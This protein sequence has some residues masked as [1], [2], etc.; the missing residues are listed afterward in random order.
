MRAI[1][2][3]FHVGAF[4]L[5]VTLPA[6][7]GPPYLTDDPEP[8]DLHHYEIYAFGSGTAMRDGMDSEAGID[9]N[10]GGAENLQLTAILPLT[11]E[12]SGKAGLGNI[13]LA[14]KYRFLEQ[15][16]FGFDVAAFPALILPS[17]SMDIGAQ[18]AALFLPLWAQKDF[19]SWSVFGGGGCTLNQSGDDRNFCSMGLAVTKEVVDGWRL[20]IEVFH[21]TADSIDAKASTSLG[22]GLTYDLSETF[23]LLAYGGPGL[24]NAG[25]AGRY[26]WYLS[27]LITF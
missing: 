5:L 6:Y 11:Y 26:N 10:Y 24:Q 19:G 4:L 8:T 27:T 1:P 20:G 23:H 22:M 21:Q 16:D 17:A 25:D 9:F 13:E 2:Q 3:P 12:P 18:H 7:A 15:D 14:A